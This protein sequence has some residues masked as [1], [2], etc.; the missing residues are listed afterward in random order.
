MQP[1][2]DL[3]AGRWE[4]RPD[5]TT[6]SKCGDKAKK[7]TDIRCLQ[8]KHMKP[9][10]EI[11]QSLTSRRHRGHQHGLQPRLHRQLLG[12]LMRENRGKPESPVT[13]I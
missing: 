8:N 1:E 5:M 13:Y 10:G 4:Q 3:Y 9:E 11:K 6:E 7:H 2:R 12:D